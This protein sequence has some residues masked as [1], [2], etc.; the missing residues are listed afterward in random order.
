MGRQMD[1]I[2]RIAPAISREYG[3]PMAAQIEAEARR[4]YQMLCQENAGDPKA[5]KQ[6]TEGNLFPGI[7]LCQAMEHA[8]VS[9]EEACGFLCREIPRASEREAEQLRKVLRF[10]GLYRL[11]PWVWK[12]ATQKMF[13]PAAGFQFHFYETGS[14]RVKFDMLECPYQKTC[15]RYGCPELTAAFCGTDDVCYGHMH[16][17]LQWNRT[18]T[19]GTG[20]DC[21]EFDIL[22]K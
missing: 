2:A 4:R 6:H 21:C 15:Q 16:P 20:G 8:G 5:V 14:R 9:H 19:L 3:Q 13:G 7:A 17:R 12:K 11:V 10:P 1:W 22:V 18:K